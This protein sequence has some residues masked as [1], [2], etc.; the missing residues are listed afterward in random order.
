M[1]KVSK[2]IWWIAAP[3]VIAAL[4]FQLYWL[5]QTYKSQREAFTATATAVFQEAYDQTIFQTVKHLSG[6]KSKEKN[7]Y[8]LRTTMMMVGDTV[9]APSDTLAREIELDSAHLPDS[10]L[11]MATG[12]PYARFFSTIISSFTNVTP[13]RDSLIMRYKA[14]LAQKGITLPFTITYGAREKDADRSTLLVNP[15]LN[16]PAKAVAVRFDGLPVYLLKKMSSAIIL[17][18]FIAFLITGCIGFLWRILLRQ[19]RLEHMKRDFISHVTHELKTPVAILQAT[20]EALLV[21]HG[22]ND[23][24]KTGRYLR[25]SKVELDKL[26]GLIDKIM[27]V[28]RLEQEQ[29]PLHIADAPIKTLVNEAVQRF[30]HLPG[31]QVLEQYDLQQPSIHTDVNA[32]HT[33]LSNLLDNAIKYNQRLQKHIQVEVKE[34]PAFFSFTVRDNGDGIAKEHIPFLYDKFYRVTQGDR[35]DTNG[36]GL[37]LSHVKALLQQLHGAI[38]VQSTPG[39]GTTF[40]FQLPKHEKDKTAAG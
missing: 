35:Q 25:H 19:E 40:T 28:T 12:T 20:N 36:Y 8:E 1:S 6:L 33:I 17:S 10:E 7:R 34:M 2:R 23:T 22:I 21:F 30:S 9:I 14:G 32:F 29:L 31:V 11:D 38:A 16:N 13:A 24:E 27:Q 15:T 37:G 18:L 39:E 26:Q 4:L 3:A 5:W